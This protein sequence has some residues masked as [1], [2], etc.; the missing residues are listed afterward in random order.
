MTYASR[1]GSNGSLKL[2]VAVVAGACAWLPLSNATEVR[3]ED[4]PF[5]QFPMVIHCKYKDTYHAFYVSRVSP[6]GVATYVASD[7][8]AGNVTLDGQAKATGGEEAGSCVGKTLEE[9]R[10]S[11]QA[12]DLKR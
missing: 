8:I 11:G 6:D 10:A 2:I 9:L 4:S 5:A 12:W 7:R 3:A 1:R